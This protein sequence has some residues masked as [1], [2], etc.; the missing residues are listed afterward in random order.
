[1]IFLALRTVP[2]PCRVFPFFICGGHNEVAKHR[3]HKSRRRCILL[4]LLH[5]QT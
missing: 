3:E 1:M 4:I 5:E 2:L